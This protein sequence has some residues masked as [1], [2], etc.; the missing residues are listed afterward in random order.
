MKT[1]FTSKP[2]SA[3]LSAVACLAAALFVPAT[4]SAQDTQQSHETSNFT[5]VVEAADRNGIDLTCAEGCAWKVLSFDVSE[6]QAI[7][8]RGMTG[9]SEENDNSATELADFL[10]TIE[11]TEEGVRLEGKRG[12]A[13]KVLT[14]SCASGECSQAVDQN[15]MV[16]LSGK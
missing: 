14:F 7:D 9:P 12:T 10:F 2:H 8:A 6:A 16:S 3:F 1:S 15:G 5:F 13:W 4:A 11:R